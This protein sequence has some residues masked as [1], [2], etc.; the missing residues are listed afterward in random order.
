MAESMNVVAIVGRLGRDPELRNTG[1]GNPVANIVLA[2]DG[3]GDEEVSWIDVVAFGKT[4]E[5]AATYLNKGRRVGVQGRLR[6]SRWETKEGGKRSKVEVIASAWFFLDSKGDGASQN[7][8]PTGGDLPVDRPSSSGGGGM[9]GDDDTSDI[10]F[11]AW[12]W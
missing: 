5:A 7:T 11:A 1:S 2:V 6:Q 4:A 9:T 10:P 3:R 12:K 8:A